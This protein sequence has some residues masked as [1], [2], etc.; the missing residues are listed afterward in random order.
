MTLLCSCDLIFL[1]MPACESSQEACHLATPPLTLVAATGLTYPLS[2][3]SCH[4]VR[5]YAAS[6]VFPR[7]FDQPPSLLAR[8]IRMPAVRVRLQVLLA[9]RIRAAA[10]YLDEQIFCGSL[11]DSAGKVHLDSN[12]STPAGDPSSVLS[13]G[14]QHCLSETAIRRI[15]WVVPEVQVGPVLPLF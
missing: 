3:P 15:R 9:R 6:S 8:P 2:H 11:V 5:R 4:R 1:Q 10:I 12:G 7:S 13:R 14:G